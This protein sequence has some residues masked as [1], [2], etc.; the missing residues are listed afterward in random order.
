M[1]FICDMGTVQTYL[2]KWEEMRISVMPL[3]KFWEK[4]RER[5]EAWCDREEIKN[6][7]NVIAEIG[8]ERRE[9]KF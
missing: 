9:K 2:G 7:G 4:V 3:S 5:R 8:R 6:C 1:M